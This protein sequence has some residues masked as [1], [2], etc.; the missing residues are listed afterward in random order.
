M[1]KCWLLLKMQI[2][3]L[4]NINRLL[5]TK[6]KKEKH[7]L[8]GMGAVVLFVYIIII[9]YSS[10]IAIGCVRL[11]M[12]SILPSIILIICAAITIG[13][14]FTKSNS[15]LFGFRDYE[16]VMSIPVKN[17]TVVTSRLLS[18][19]ITNLFISFAVMIPPI[20]VYGITM[21]TPLRVWLIMAISIFLAPLLPM[22]IS[23]VIGT[24]ITAISIRF[25]YKNLLTTVLSIAAILAL[26]GSLSTGVQWDDTSL[27]KIGT[28]LAQTIQ[29][30]YPPAALFTNALE[31]ANWGSFEE[32]TLLS[33][34]AT[35]FFVLLLSA[36]YDKIN[37]ALF[38]VRTKNSYQ[39][40][41]LS[42]ST[43]LKSLYVK[44]MRRLFSCP[45]YVLNSSLGSILLVAVCVVLLFTNTGQIDAILGI[46]NVME[47]GRKLA[48]WF[49][50][51]FIGL[52]STT[53]SSISIEGKSRWLMCSS[54]VSTKTIL[55]AKIA[56]NLTIQ[57]PS[58]LVS[59][60]LLS[61]SLGTNA[62]ETIM[63]FIIPLLFSGYISVIG[64]SFNLKFP[65]YDWMSEVSAVK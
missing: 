60:T 47:W 49:A 39:M 22:M 29:S 30:T 56:V 25:R 41:T 6:D 13:I 61:I 40:G 16:I 18:I 2:L 58:I 7:Q 11:G 8:I 46:P 5:H 62:T 23:I 17:I 53:A 48:P 37:F 12:K 28:S 19:Y 45:I 52:S 20:I 33:V 10:F 42:E 9:V 50:A 55:D 15:V 34:G 24:F 26:M 31:N 44:E 38:S 21:N 59:S 35:T 27:V 3:S 64:L 1:S 14:T 54:P 63:L 32:F 4:F 43:P 65:K 51:A 36:F 57:V